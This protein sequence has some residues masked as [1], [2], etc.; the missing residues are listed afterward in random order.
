MGQNSGDVQSIKEAFSRGDPDKAVFL[1]KSLF[2]QGANL[3]ERWGEIAQIALQL[4]EITL[5]VKASK[6]FAKTDRKDV[7]RQ[8]R[9]AALLAEAGQVRQAHMV[10]APFEKKAAGNPS[11]WHFMGTVK[12]L[13]GEREAAKQDFLKVLNAWPTAGQSW[14]AYAALKTFTPDDPDLAK[15]EQLSGQMSGVDPQTR[16]AFL[17]AL[18][19]AWEDAGDIDRSFLYYKKGARLFHQNRP[20]DHSADET[21]CKQAVQSYTAKALAELPSS[22]CE[23]SRPIFVTGLPR[24]GT[25]L[26]EQILASH[27]KV[28]DGGELN[29]FRIALMPLGGFSFEH[30]RRFSAGAGR[31][32][33]WNHLA[34][35]YLYLLEER[36]GRGGRIVDK[37]LNHSRFI[38]LIRHVLPEAKIIWVRRDPNDTAWSC[39]KTYFNRGMNWTYSLE[40][41]A[42]YFKMEDILFTHWRKEFPE[43]I[44]VVHYEELVRDPE[45]VIPAM[46]THCNLEDESQTRKFYE[47][48]RSVAT[49]S[50]AQVRKPLT[51]A[52]IGR[53][54]PYAAH[55]KPFRNLYGK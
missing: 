37:T 39:F 3:G 9:H 31:H 22:Q 29:L 25:T 17:Y 30:A 40:G 35:K 50:L 11:I 51:Q 54:K 36:F 26:V 21:F 48:R 2:R 16:G 14:F 12:S 28:K 53:W 43:R 33:T 1:I 20:F 34:K 5:A 19:K 44:H 52:S 8:L 23:S 7:M 27:T 18:G 15:M 41:I 42:H 6:R 4:G 49:A 55:L 45:V 47:T 24:S 10:M 32:T 46:L 38:G 13:L